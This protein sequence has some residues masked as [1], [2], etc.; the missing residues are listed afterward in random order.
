MKIE[1]AQVSSSFEYQK[2]GK[3]DLRDQSNELAL[4]RQTESQVDSPARSFQELAELGPLGFPIL[5]RRT[6]AVKARGPVDPAGNEARRT[7][8]AVRSP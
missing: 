7:L 4:L 1:V 8:P 6:L 5:Q 3:R 2:Q